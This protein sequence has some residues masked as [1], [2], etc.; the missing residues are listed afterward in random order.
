[1]SQPTPDE[2]ERAAAAGVR[3]VVNLRADGETGFDWEAESAERLGL[4]YVRIPIRG[5]VDLTPD[6]AAR[7]DAVLRDAP[8]PALVHCASGNRVGALLALR[9]AWHRGQDP[10]AALAVGLDAGLTNLEPVIRE[11]LGLPPLA[12]PAE[13]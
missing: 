12:A 6:N 3:T 1:M 7:L 10:A 2:L 5:A 9:E 8:G 11:K 13:E 4:R